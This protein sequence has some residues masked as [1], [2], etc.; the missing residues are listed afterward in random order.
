MQNIVSKKIMTD[1][2]VS[3]VMDALTIGKKQY[4]KLISERITGID[5]KSLH[6]TIS[7]NNLVLFRSKHIV[8]KGK[9]KLEKSAL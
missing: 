7:K 5:R 9:A 2:A 1:D 6:S 8:K 3:S 4:M